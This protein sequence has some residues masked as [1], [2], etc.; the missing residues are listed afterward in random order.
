MASNRDSAGSQT[1]AAL[2]R[3][4]AGARESGREVTGSQMQ[5]AG[6]EIVDKQVTG[7]LGRDFARGS[8]APTF[9]E[10]AASRTLPV[11]ERFVSVNGEGRAAG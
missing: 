1:Q 6:G 4:T 11:A 9:S 8:A 5:T 3:D 10:P 2:G 7:V